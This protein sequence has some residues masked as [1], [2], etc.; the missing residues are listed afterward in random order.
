M[1]VL[2]R[3]GVSLTQSSQPSKRGDARHRRRSQIGK[4]AGSPELGDPFMSWKSSPESAPL[5]FFGGVSE[6]QARG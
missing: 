6:F 4:A 3:S 5:F 1:G 2:L